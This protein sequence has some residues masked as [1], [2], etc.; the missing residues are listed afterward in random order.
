MSDLT[1]QLTA[2]LGDRYAIEQ[3]IGGGRM[4]HVFRAHG[5]RHDRQIALKGLRP[6]LAAQ[7]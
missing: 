7:K 1:G 6:E 3:S 4:A 2:A 5:R